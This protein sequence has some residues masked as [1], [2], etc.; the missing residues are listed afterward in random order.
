MTIQ[1]IFNTAQSIEIDRRK[2]V[3]QTVSRSERIR[4]AERASGN[5]FKF[6]VTPLARFKYS[7]VRGVI[8]SIQSYDRKEEQT[9][10][11]SAIPK[12]NYLTQYQGSCS[13][14]QLNAM[15]I[16]NFSS[17]TITIG[18]LPSVSTATVLFRAGDWIQ[19]QQ[20]RYPY[21]VSTDVLRGST[22]TVEVSVHRNRITSEAVTITGPIY[23]GTATTLKVIVSEL[24]TYRLVNN[25]FAE[26]TG[27][28]TVVERIV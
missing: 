27:N 24:P 17:A 14:A 20:S 21:I 4:V 22:S 13:L 15:T 10:S 19:P 5:A 2:I 16:T 6:T 1:V 9:I 28:F 18:T 25:N 11:L 7:D 8:E 26:F 12:L 3:G 23:V